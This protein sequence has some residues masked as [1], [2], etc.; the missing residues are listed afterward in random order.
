MA[1]GGGVTMYV[2]M[3]LLS[4]YGNDTMFLVGG[5]YVPSRIR[6][7]ANMSYFVERLTE[8]SERT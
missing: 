8:L 5:R 1:P 2:L 6:I 7:E 4:L 3:N